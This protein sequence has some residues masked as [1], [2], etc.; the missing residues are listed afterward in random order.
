MPDS[1]WFTTDG[2]RDMFWP[3]PYINPLP[4]LASA[5]PPTLRDGSMCASTRK[6][7]VQETHHMSVLPKVQPVTGGRALP[8]GLGRYAAEG[9]TPSGSPLQSTYL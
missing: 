5:P 3:N 8:A 1:F 4:M 6:R 7:E 2:V 9:A